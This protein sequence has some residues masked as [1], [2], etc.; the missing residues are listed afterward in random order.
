MLFK[1]NRRKEH[2][3]RNEDLGPPSGWR[4][5]RRSVERRMPEIR[6]ISM[7]TEEFMAILRFSQE[8][9]RRA[10][11]VAQETEAEPCASEALGLSSSLD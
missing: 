7:P 9:L 10:A 4:D 6:E 8:A 11:N 2:E 5:R 3:R 1:T